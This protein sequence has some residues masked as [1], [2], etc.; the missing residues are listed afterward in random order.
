MRKVAQ[1][2]LGFHKSQPQNRCQAAQIASLFLQER[3][4]E[5]L[6]STTTVFLA[7][8]RANRAPASKHSAS[9]DQDLHILH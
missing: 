3:G 8:G 5:H 2:L 1:N 4:A 9:S 6:K 7:L